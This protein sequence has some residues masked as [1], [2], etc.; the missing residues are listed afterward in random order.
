ML[1]NAPR[2]R[3]LPASQL[4]RSAMAAHRLSVSGIKTLFPPPKEQDLARFELHLSLAENLP[5]DLEIPEGG[6]V[7]ELD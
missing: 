1:R 4:Q 3:T 7:R 5:D 2:P 6:V